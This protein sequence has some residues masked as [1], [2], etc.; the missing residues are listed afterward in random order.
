MLRFA[1]E[2][3]CEGPLKDMEWAR[4]P[5]VRTGVRPTIADRG[6]TAQFFASRGVVL[7]PKAQERFL[8]CVL[9]NYLSALNLLARRA[10]GDYGRD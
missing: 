8:D 5:E 1:P 3:V 6:D 10:R 7:T 2:E 9:D 4:D